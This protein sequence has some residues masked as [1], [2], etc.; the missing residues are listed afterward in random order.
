[1]GIS[2]VSNFSSGSLL[3][4]AAPTRTYALTPS[5]LATTATQE[6]AIG[7]SAAPRV[8]A[9]Q[10]AARAL[11]IEDLSALVAEAQVRARTI[12]LFG[13]GSNATSVTSPNG[14]VALDAAPSFDEWLRSES[15]SLSSPPFAGLETDTDLTDALSSS[16]MTDPA[17]ENGDGFVSLTEELAYAQAHALDS[18]FERGDALRTG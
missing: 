2:S 4:G 14:F 11:R 18:F 13:N 15:S 10:Y 5:P 7:S 6:A 3:P 16:L 12:E 8:T 17:D 1:M 9:A